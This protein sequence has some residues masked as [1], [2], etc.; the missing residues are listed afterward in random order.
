MLFYD[1]LL[2]IKFLTPQIH[3]VLYFMIMI[4]S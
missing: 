2:W 1:Q 3:D 4:Q